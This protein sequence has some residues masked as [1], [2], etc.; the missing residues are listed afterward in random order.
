MMNISC[1]LKQLRSYAIKTFGYHNF[2]NGK[3]QS[4]V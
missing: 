1:S 3:K 4:E 2:A